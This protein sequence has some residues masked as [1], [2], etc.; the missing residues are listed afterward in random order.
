MKSLP[1]KLKLIAIA[2]VTC[3]WAAA[4]W[5]QAFPVKPIRCIV[6]SSPGG[7][8]DATTRLIANAL[9]SVLGH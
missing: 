7:G 2:V 9:P 1:L 3:M 5:G 8:A 4:G 6:P